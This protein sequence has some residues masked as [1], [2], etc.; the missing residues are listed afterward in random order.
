[1]SFLSFKIHFHILDF[2][3]YSI[4]KSLTV[5]VIHYAWSNDLIA[6]ENLRGPD[7]IV[8][9]SQGSKTVNHSLTQGSYT[10][11]N[12]WENWPNMLMRWQQVSTNSFV[13]KTNHFYGT[14]EAE[15]E[16][17]EEGII[18]KKDWLLS[19]DGLSKQ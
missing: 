10:A 4:L 9:F 14:T 11:R 13:T 18:F 12:P 8:K 2:D 19:F 16:S 15:A 3:A 17:G 6:N 7:K 5:V 1:M